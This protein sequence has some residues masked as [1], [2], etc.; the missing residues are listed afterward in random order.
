MAGFTTLTD[1]ASNFNPLR[2]N[3]WTIDFVPTGTKNRVIELF[4]ADGKNLDLYAQN[5]TLPSKTMEFITINIHGSERQFPT[6]FSFE[7]NFSVTFQETEKLDVKSRFERWVQACH[8]MQTNL[9]GTGQQFMA[10]GDKFT[11]DGEYDLATDIVFTMYKYSSADGNNP[12]PVVQYRMNG[13]MPSKV[14]EPTTLD[15]TDKTS[16]VTTTVDFSVDWPTQ[17]YNYLDAN[18]SKTILGIG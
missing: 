17:V 3:L 16:I 4:F 6:K 10:T 9:D 15:R 14:S 12:E 2:G 11:E 8:P 7:H 13:T 5:V 18:Q 1:K